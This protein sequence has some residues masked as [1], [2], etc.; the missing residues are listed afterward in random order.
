MKLKSLPRLAAGV[1]L[2]SLLSHAAV[3]APVVLY[4]NSEQEPKA[5]V[6]AS[7]RPRGFAV[8]TSEAIL[9]GAGI[10]YAIKGLPFPRAIEEVKACWGIMAGVF[11]TEERSKFL[12][13]SDAIVPDK[14]VVVTRSNDS[15]D[16]TKLEDLANRTAT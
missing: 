2:L 12:A 3:A 13:F 8:E 1:F 6:D 11:K 9:K 15:F 7:G 14:F 4:V 10:D 16:F 5:W